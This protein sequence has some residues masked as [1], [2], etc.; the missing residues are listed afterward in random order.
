MKAKEIREKTTEE[1]N[2]LLTQWRGEIFTLNVQ[3]VTGQ[4]GQYGRV[5]ALKKNIA[6]AL[7][8]LQEQ[9]GV[10]TARREEREAS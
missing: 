1:L 9:E 7:T 6:R 8:I 3:A 5:R 2:H 10:A 4:T